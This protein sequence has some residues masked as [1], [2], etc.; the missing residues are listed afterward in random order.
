MTNNLRVYQEGIEFHHICILLISSNEPLLGCSP[1]LDWL[2]ENQFI[3][4]MDNTDDNCAS[5]DS[6][7][8][9]KGS[10]I[11]R[12]DL[13]EELHERFSTWLVSSMETQTC[14]LVVLD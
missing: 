3:Y 4:T 9:L 1:L 7:S 13:C 14:T 11:T 12:L 6:S 5:G 10:G 2:R 8:S